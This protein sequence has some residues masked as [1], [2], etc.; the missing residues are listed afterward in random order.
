MYLNIC[1]YYQLFAFSFLLASSDLAD[2]V[3][4]FLT[5]STDNQLGK[6]ASFYTKFVLIAIYVDPRHYYY[7]LRRLE[8]FLIIFC[9]IRT[10]YNICGDINADYLQ[11]HCKIQELDLLLATYN[12]ASICHKNCK[13]IQYCNR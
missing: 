1:L 12:L 6:V 13:R 8:S 11:N 3:L 4:M 2:P 10:E 7:F 5:S 9:T